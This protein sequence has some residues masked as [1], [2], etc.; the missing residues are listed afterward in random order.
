[1][2]KEDD[3]KQN[4]KRR[5]T[6]VKNGKS[7]KKKNASNSNDLKKIDTDEQWWGAHAFLYIR[8]W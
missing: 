4:F 7:E 1:M 3:I 5:T 2:I 6:K 8:V